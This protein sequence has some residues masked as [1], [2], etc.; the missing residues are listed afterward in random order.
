MELRELIERY[1]EE[2]KKHQE[3]VDTYQIKL[4]ALSKMTQ[5]TFYEFYEHIL[6][7][8]F[9]TVEFENKSYECILGVDGRG[10]A[11][12]EWRN[13]IVMTVRVREKYYLLNEHINALTNYLKEKHKGQY[14]HLDMQNIT[15]S[16]I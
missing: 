11:W 9:Y 8:K 6:N 4:E 14:N 13:G 16:S 3:C 12:S 1:T 7:D 15:P 10:S 2:Q 5:P